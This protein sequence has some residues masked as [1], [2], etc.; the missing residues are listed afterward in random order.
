MWLAL[1]RRQNGCV[2]SILLP[3]VGIGGIN[4]I[5]NAEGPLVHFNGIL[6]F[7]PEHI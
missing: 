2:C 1:Y 4:S 7:F 5:V 3:S 6:A